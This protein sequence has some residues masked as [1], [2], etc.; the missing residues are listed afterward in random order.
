MSQETRRVLVV[1]DDEGHGEALADGLEIDGYDCVV[2]GSGTAGVEAMQG[3][4]F[5]AVLDRSRDARR[6]RLEVLREAKVSARTRPC[7]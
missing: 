1:D 2:V 7:C 6:S 3:G 4:E 5:D